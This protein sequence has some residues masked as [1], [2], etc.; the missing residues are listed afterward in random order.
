MKRVV[1]TGMGVV[2]PNGVGVNNF[3]ESLFYARSGIKKI[4]ELEELNFKCQV[5]GICSVDFKKAVDL[6]PE[7]NI[8]FISRSTIMAVTACKEALE[9]AG[10]LFK[11]DFSSTHDYD[12]IIGSSIGPADLWGDKIIPMVNEKKHLRFGSYV[13]GQINN[14]SPV[15]MISGIW[16]ISGRILSTS[17]ACASGTEAII[18]AS[19]RIKNGKCKIVIA[20][21]VD[22][23]SKYYW[24]TM[25]A[26]RV[27]NPNFNHDPKQASRPMSSS[28]KGF[29]P[30]EG[31][32][33]FII[34]E[35]K[36]AIERNAPILAEIVGSHLNCGGQ[37]NGGSMFAINFKKLTECL[38]LAIKDAGIKPEE[39]DYISGH[40]TA[41]KYDPIEIEAWVNTLGLKKENFPMIN[42]TKSLIGHTIGASGAIEIV[43]S[44][45]QMSNSFIHASINCEDTH[46]KILEFITSGSIPHQRIDNKTIK[47][48]AKANFGFGDVNACLILKN[49]RD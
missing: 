2:A 9:N 12:I 20:G 35:Y 25:D 29:I 37:R 4:D 39:I 13:L 11:Y 36:H 26:M 49:P 34:E 33:I 14:L 43:A 28:A 15:A 48:L 6:F 10:L 38:T 47:Y 7:M 24:A 45:I 17:Y 40:L 16:G 42:S 31:S 22:P 27:T 46:P 30:A 21:G 44:I 3:A 41:T 5:G 18:E 8:P 23:Y 1:I 19:N 32:A